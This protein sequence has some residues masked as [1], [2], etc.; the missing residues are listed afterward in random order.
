[1]TFDE[2]DWERALCYDAEYVT[3]KT[4]SKFLRIQKK[5]V[6]KLDDEHEQL[7]LSLMNLINH[8]G[9]SHFDKETMSPFEMSG[10]IIINDDFCTFNER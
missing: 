10:F 7:A 8:K 5:E 9:M 3:C 1:M 2:D 4:Y 6:D